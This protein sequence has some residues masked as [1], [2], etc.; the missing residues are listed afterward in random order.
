MTL[1]GGMIWIW[2]D[3]S[4]V[5][6]V[7]IVTGNIVVL[8]IP[9]IQA[10]PLTAKAIVIDF[11]DGTA[12]AINILDLLFKVGIAAAKAGATAI[13]KGEGRRLCAR[14]IWQFHLGQSA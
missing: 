5:L 3:G 6:H 11:G 9:L 12:T 4:R 8:T 13:A 1:R 2:Y 10:L 14:T 7:G